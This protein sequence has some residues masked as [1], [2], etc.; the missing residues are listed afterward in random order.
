M[1]AQGTPFY[2]SIPGLWYDRR[3]DEHSI[4]SRTDGNVWAPFYEMPWARSGT[5]MAADGLSQFDLSRFNTWYY[6]RFR[7]FGQLCDRNGLVLYHNLYNTHNT[8]EI[9][10]H[11][12]DYPGGRRITSIT[13]GCRNRRLSSR[14]ITCTLPTK[15]M[16]W[17]IPSAARSTA[18]LSCMS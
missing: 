3:R 9:P 4:V 12:I 16:M 1:V 6:E 10:P 8:L 2:Q 13:P 17:P 14:A 18:L 11:W 15:F 5:G 7:E